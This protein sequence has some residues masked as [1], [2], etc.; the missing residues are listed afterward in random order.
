MVVLSQPRPASE[1]DVSALVHPGVN[2]NA[3]CE[4]QGDHEERKVVAIRQQHVVLVERIQHFA[5]QGGFASFFVSFRQACMKWFGEFAIVSGFTFR[6]A[7][8]GERESTRNSA[9]VGAGT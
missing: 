9:G 1:T 6:E 5:R 2:I 4:Q 7:G 3:V 8:D